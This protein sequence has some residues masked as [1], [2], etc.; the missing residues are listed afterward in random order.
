MSEKIEKHL[1]SIHRELRGTEQDLSRERQKSLK[2]YD[3]DIH[4]RLGEWLSAH[5]L[6]ASISILMKK[7]PTEVKSHDGWFV[8]DRDHADPC[9]VTL[10]I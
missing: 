8:P 7:V 10:R 9:Q 1:E 3:R 5:A 4:H 2:Y 6:I